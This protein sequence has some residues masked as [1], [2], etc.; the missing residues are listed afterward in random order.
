VRQS[1]GYRHDGKPSIK[2]IRV[3]TQLIAEAEQPVLYVGGGVIKSDASPE[4]HEFAEITGIPV[5]RP[6]RASRP[7]PPP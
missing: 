1:P 2:Q 3:A 5:V 4:L 6:T 7:A